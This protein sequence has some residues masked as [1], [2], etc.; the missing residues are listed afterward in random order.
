MNF[1]SECR[2]ASRR[3]SR[4]KATCGRQQRDEKK[5]RRT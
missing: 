1:Y 4:Y 2:I 3:G 5:V